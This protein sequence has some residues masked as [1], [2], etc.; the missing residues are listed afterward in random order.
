MTSR[1]PKPSRKMLESHIAKR[2]EAEARRANEDWARDSI[3]PSVNFVD[4]EGDTFDEDLFT[5]LMALA[6]ATKG[7]LPRS[8]AEALKEPEIWGEPMKEEMNQ[9]KQKGVWRLVD[10]PEGERALDGMWVFDVKVD[11]EG[12]IVKRKAR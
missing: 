1:I 5:T 6:S 10:L 8:G 4:L 12:N 9:M 11:G 2:E 3:R 7:R